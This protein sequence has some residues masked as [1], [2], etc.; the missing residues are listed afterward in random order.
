MIGSLK[1]K[2]ALLGKPARSKSGNRI[3]PLSELSLLDVSSLNKTQLTGRSRPSTA[4][5][6]Q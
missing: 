1:H 5:S 2:K 3:K 4:S 6:Q